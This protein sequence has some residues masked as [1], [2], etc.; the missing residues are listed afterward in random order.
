MQVAGA[1][2]HGPCMGWG[3][4]VPVDDVGGPGRVVLWPQTGAGAEDL[5]GQSLGGRMG[6][7]PHPPHPHLIPQD[8]HSLHSTSRPS[9]SCSV[10]HRNL[11]RHLLTGGETEARR[12]RGQGR[13]CAAAAEGR[14]LGCRKSPSSAP[15]DLAT[16]DWVSG[17]PASSCP[18]PWPHL[19]QVPSLHPSLSL[20]T[21]Q[22][23][24]GAV[25][26]PVSGPGEAPRRQRGHQEPGEAVGSLT[27][28]PWISQKRNPATE[29]DWADSSKGRKWGRGRGHRV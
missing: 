25:G 16:G 8:P 23:R 28:L 6:G 17:C 27:L 13:V 19:G 4:G 22:H 29:R 5:E 18:Q 12:T 1:R 20:R 2:D 7:S 11:T 9:P 14:G 3:C 15:T 24:P 10:R 21:A 26:F